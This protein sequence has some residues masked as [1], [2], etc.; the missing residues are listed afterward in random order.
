LQK[1]FQVKGYKY[2]ITNGTG[3][4]IV[5]IA[6][7][8]NHDDIKVLIIVDDDKDGKE[9]KDKILKIDGVYSE[10]NVFTIRDIVGEIIDKGTIE[11]VL[12]KDF[13]ESK[14]KE[15]YKSEFGEDFTYNLLE[16]SPFLDQI[17][18][19]LQQKSK[20]KNEIL[21]KFKKRV[22]D[23]FNPTKTTFDTKFPLL[24]TLVD[25]IQN[26]LK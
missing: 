16:T 2:G 3:S 23:D 22:S 7:K 17:K 19:F 26:K 11:D 15:F 8:L 1:A 24:K 12:G 14:L 10:E 25:E 9:Y 21:D 13:I 18:I 20:F 5:Q 4:N 6:S